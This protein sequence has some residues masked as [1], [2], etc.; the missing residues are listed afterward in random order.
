M[1]AEELGELLG[2]SKYALTFF[3]KSEKITLNER[4]GDREIGVKSS[5]LNLGSSSQETDNFLLCLKGGSEGPKP[6][7]RFTHVDDPCR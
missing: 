4:L 5:S 3:F 6:W 1:V 2:L 7:K